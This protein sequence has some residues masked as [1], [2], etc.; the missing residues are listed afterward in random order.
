MKILEN[1]YSCTG[2][3]ASYYEPQLPSEITTTSVIAAIQVREALKIASGSES[4]IL[5]RMFFYNGE[6]NLSQEMEIE[7]NPRCQ[8]HIFIGQ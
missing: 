8:H 7:V 1:R 5:N 6:K 3:P 2:S 4:V